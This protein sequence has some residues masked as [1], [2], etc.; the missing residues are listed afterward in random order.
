MFF[1]LIIAIIAH[2]ISSSYLMFC[3]CTIF[4]FDLFQQSGL[5]FMELWEPIY[6]LAHVC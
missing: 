2:A 5:W 6:L 4:V 1:F 3:I